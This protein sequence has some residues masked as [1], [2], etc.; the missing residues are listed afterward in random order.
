MIWFIIG[1]FLGLI[2]LLVL[3]ILPSKSLEV[4]PVMAATPAPESKPEIALSGEPKIAQSSP[5]I[6]PQK[7]WYYLDNE[8]KRFGPMSF[9]RLKQAW[10][11]DSI[12]TDTYVWNED[13]AGWKPLEELSEILTQFRDPPPVT[14]S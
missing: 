12:D 9:D 2:A 10:N 3:Y 8:D 7:L 13:M 14:P 5:S 1:V 4:A 6:V 11:E